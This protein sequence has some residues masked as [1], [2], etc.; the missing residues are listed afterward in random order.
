MDVS[1]FAAAI[2]GTTEPAD[3]YELAKNPLPGKGLPV[4]CLPTTAGTGSET[5]RVSVFTNAKGEKVWAWGDELRASLALLDPQLTVGLP[6]HLTAATGVD[7]LVHAIEAC[8]IRRANLLNDAVSLHAIRLVVGNLKRAVEAPDDLDARGAMQ[9]AAAAA[10][11]AIDNAGTGIA[12]AMGHA[13]GAIGHVHHGR[14]VGLCLRAAIGWNAEAS[15][16]RHA[17]VATAMGVPSEGRAEAAVVA[18]LAP[19]FDSFV[20]SVGLAVSLAKDGL[21]TAD[22]QRLAAAT[23]APENKAMRD[24]NIREIKPGDAERIA[25]IV[26]SAA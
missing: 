22:T 6:P 13:L 11:I 18:D 23:M 17:A 19:R 25:G 12:H 15:P 14:A 1:K 9:I 2:A 16:A 5:T 8:T 4:I 24:S 10:G 21:S 20:R 3:H 7:A 26:L